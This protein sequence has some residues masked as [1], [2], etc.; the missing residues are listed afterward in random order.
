[1]IAD[2]TSQ[3]GKN[4]LPL[5]ARP[6]ET[7]K[8]VILGSE[9]KMDTMHDHQDTPFSFCHWH[10]MTETGLRCIRCDQPICA[11]CA[12]FTPV[13][14]CCPACLKAAKDK[15]FNATVWDYLVVT[16]ISSGM[17]LV[18]GFGVLA[19][20]FFLPLIFLLPTLWASWHVGRLIGNFSTRV[21][22][23]KR[24]R[25]LP[26][27]AAAMV[28]CGALMPFLFVS[29]TAVFLGDGFPVILP[30]LYLLSAPAGAF[31]AMQW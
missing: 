25:Y 27:T 3:S 30:T 15:Q 21:T 14:Y 10:P 2:T 11:T 18:V 22:C 4:T 28:I 12:R 19:I 23:R 9:A 5:N 8:R 29:L 31:Q 17:S 6:H 16:I 20:A 1:M 24:G 7:N 26:H 13:G